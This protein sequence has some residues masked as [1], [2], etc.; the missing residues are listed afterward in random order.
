MSKL[1]AWIA[2]ST[3]TYAFI[4]FGKWGKNVFQYNLMVEGEG[5]TTIHVFAILFG[6]FWPLWWLGMFPILLLIGRH[7]PKWFETQRR[8]REKYGRR[9]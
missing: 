7:G 4:H 6:I 1:L 3:L 9:K 5:P 2:I 8:L